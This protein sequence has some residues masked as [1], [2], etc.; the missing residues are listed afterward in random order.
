MPMTV[1]EALA[2]SGYRVFVLNINRHAHRTRARQ[3]V[4]SKKAFKIAMGPAAIDV[5]YVDAGGWVSAR[6]E[7]KQDAPYDTHLGHVHKTIPKIW[8]ED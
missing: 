4:R 7:D 8:R 6:S 2:M 3:Y 5:W 1:Q